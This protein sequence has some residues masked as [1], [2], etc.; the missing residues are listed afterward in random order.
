[1]AVRGVGGDGGFNFLSKPLA[2]ET[3]NNHGSIPPISDRIGATRVL[4]KENKKKSICDLKD[5]EQKF[6]VS[7][8]N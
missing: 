2:P 1:M 7:R 4:W 5:K 6:K 8:V 3:N